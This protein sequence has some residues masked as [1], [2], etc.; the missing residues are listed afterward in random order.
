[1]MIQVPRILLQLLPAMHAPMLQATHLL[2]EMPTFVFIAVLQN[3]PSPLE[4]GACFVVAGA[5][6]SESEAVQIVFAAF[7][8]LLALCEWHVPLAVPRHYITCRFLSAMCMYAFH[9]MSAPMICWAFAHP[10]FGKR[11]HSTTAP[12]SSETQSGASEH[13]PGASEHISLDVAIAKLQHH[14]ETD[15]CAS[16]ILAAAITLRD[17]TGRDRKESLHR[18]T[19]TKWGVARSIQI[20]GSWRNR[21]LQHIA[22]DLAVTVCNAAVRWE[23]QCAAK[24]EV[25]ASTTGAPEHNCR[26]HASDVVSSSTAQACTG[27]V[28]KLKET[29]NDVCTLRRLGA[30]TFEATLKSGEVWTGD[31]VLLKTLPQGEAKFATLTVREVM[32]RAK[33]KTKAKAKAQAKANEESRP[34]NV[35]EAMAVAK[36]PKPFRH[37]FESGASKHSG[38]AADLVVQTEAEVDSERLEPV[39]D[40]TEDAITDASV[41]EKDAL[42]QAKPNKRRRIESVVGMEIGAAEHAAKTDA[43]AAN[44]GAELFAQS[45]GHEH[46]S[47]KWLRANEAHAYCVALLQQIMQWTGQTQLMKMR[48][49]AKTHGITLTNKVRYTTEGVRGTVRRHFAKAIAQEKGRLACFQFKATTSEHMGPACAELLQRIQSAAIAR[50]DH[51]LQSVVVDFANYLRPVGR[52]STENL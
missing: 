4:I 27:H 13:A 36:R 15:E 44:V 41:A 21:P 2:L 14:E 37:V 20:D 50:G 10:T 16:D 46:D 43:N 11:D 17:S 34:T 25:R 3:M 9:P 28:E 52:T 38:G 29:P 19:G 40:E 7:V 1:M 48:T 39:P 45:D 51:F 5:S 6:E 30:D 18:M 22:Q 33:A 31:A 35:Q 49:L 24:D 12:A 47:I 8:L 32:A 23:H 26:I 42:G